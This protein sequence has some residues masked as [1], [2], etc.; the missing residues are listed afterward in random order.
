MSCGLLIAKG[1]T[2]KSHPFWTEEYSPGSY[3]HGLPVICPV[4]L[5]KVHVFVLQLA[6]CA[7][8]WKVFVPTAAT[9]VTPVVALKP[10]GVPDVIVPAL[11]VEFA[12]K[13]ASCA[14]AAFLRSDLTCASWPRFL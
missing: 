2:P 13:Y 11:Y 1:V 6:C 14:T 7:V 8:N 5:L 10:G 12:A 9:T 4:P 3:G